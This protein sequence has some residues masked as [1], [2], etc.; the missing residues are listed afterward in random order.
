MFTQTI[1]MPVIYQKCPVC[2]GRGMVG[3]GF[4]NPYQQMAITAS[5]DPI[6]CRTCKGKTIIHI[7][8]EI[9]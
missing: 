7:M 1:S 2:D 8:E 4:Y 9:E 6:E 5:M 3:F